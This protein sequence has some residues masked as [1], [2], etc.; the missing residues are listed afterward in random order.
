MNKAEH[1][2]VRSIKKQLNKKQLYEA[3][4]RELNERIERQSAFA[5][6]YWYDQV[7]QKHLVELT[8]TV[9][10]KLVGSALA[11]ERSIFD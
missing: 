7:G 9:R 2:P 5:P 1:K 10:W 6:T 11:I 4:I 8:F 3:D